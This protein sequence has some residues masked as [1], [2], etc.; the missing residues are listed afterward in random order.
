MVLALRPS[1]S[2][3]LVMSIFMLH[4]VHYIHIFRVIEIFYSSCSSEVAETVGN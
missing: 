4:V 1:H 2:I 3:L